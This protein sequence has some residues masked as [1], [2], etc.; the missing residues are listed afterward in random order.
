MW[1]IF[2]MGRAMGQLHVMRSTACRMVNTIISGKSLLGVR[3]AP[4]PL[5]LC[6][7]LPKHARLTLF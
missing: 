3:W 1:E 6:Y 4:L 5:L 7:D 2:T